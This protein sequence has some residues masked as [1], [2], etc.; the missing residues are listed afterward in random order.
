MGKRLLSVDIFRGFTIF[1]MVFVNDVASV[2]G[3]PEWMKHAGTYDDCMTFVDVVFPAFL[4]I[5]GMAI[6]LAVRNR[7]SKGQSWA[8]VWVH[9][10]V[11][12][13][14]LL[15]LGV[16]MVNAGEMN[17]EA[18]LL[19]AWLWNSLLYTSAILIW[20][21][22]PREVSVKIRNRNRGLQLLG[23]AI[24]VLLALTFRKGEAPGLI[25]ITPSW[26]G[27][28][29]LIGWA[30]LY[31]L[32]IYFF[33]RTN[34][35]A[36]AA[37]IGLLMVTVLGLQYSDA[38]WPAVINWLKGQAGNYSHT[39]ITLSGTLFSMLLL[40][41]Y[42][43]RSLKDRLQLMIGFGVL[44]GLAGLF[45]R[46]IGGISKN[47]AT[48]TW[49]L[50][51]VAICCGVFTLLYWLVD[52]RGRKNWFRFLQPA[53]ENPLLTYILPF[54]FYAVGGFE[55]LPEVWKHGGPGIIRS[56]VFSLLI[57]GLA[58]LLA[59]RGIRLKL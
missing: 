54:V 6:P 46:P 25:G 3:I 44:A 59:N 34:L 30:Y 24:L 49:G 7:L 58:R 17:K 8:E 45:I 14:G 41:V 27:I 16:Y 26:W 1:M 52:V 19:P 51:S 38:E 56:L 29:G 9:V 55:F 20:N 5:V 2:S 23:A 11:R 57:L 39:L 36:M 43:D 13:C 4:F 10:L 53:G 15:V 42:R 21:E 35:V 50:Y 22:Y 31:T 40:Q 48:P 32:V 12:T 47:L 37:M 33:L 28:L 18:N